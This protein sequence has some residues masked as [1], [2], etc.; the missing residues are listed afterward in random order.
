MRGVWRAASSGWLHRYLRTTGA[1]YKRFAANRASAAA[2][3]AERRVSIA[4]LSAGGGGGDRQAPGEGLVAA[5]TAVPSLFF[6]EDFSLSR[7]EHRMAAASIMWQNSGRSVACPPAVAARVGKDFVTSSRGLR[8]PS[9]LLVP[10]RPLARECRPSPMSVEFAGH[11]VPNMMRAWLGS[12][13][14]RGRRWRPVTRRS[15]AAKRWSSWPRTWTSSR[16]SCSRRSRYGLC[17]AIAHCIARGVP[18]GSGS[19]SPV[20]RVGFCLRRYNRQ[21]AKL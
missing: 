6:Q 15:S 11:A 14:R 8:R 12:G 13:L 16:R 2:D 20:L 18:H 10:P 4:E 19:D 21:K 3:S 5:M 9:G 17:S 1:A 7:W